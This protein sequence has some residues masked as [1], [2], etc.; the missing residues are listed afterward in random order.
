M[1]EERVVSRCSTLS[2][3]RRQSVPRISV[4]TPTRNRPCL[5]LRAIQSVLAQ[6]DVDFEVIVVDDGSTDD[7]WK[8]LGVAK[9]GNTDLI[10]IRQSGLGASVARNRGV[11]ESSG[12]FV[13]FLDSD[14]E[15]LPGA[16]NSLVGAVVNEDIVVVCSGAVIVDDSGAV[17]ETKHPRN[18]GPAYENQ[19]G[20]FLAG[21]FMVRRDVF[22]E[23]GGFDPACPST[24]HKDLALRLVPHC[25]RNG[26]SIVSVAATTVRVHA[27][28]GQHLRSDLQALLDGRLH[29]LNVHERQLRKS[30]R[31]YSYYCETAAV[32][33]A[34]LRRFAEAQSLFRRAIDS[35]PT[36]KSTY[37]RLVAAHIPA[38]RSIIWR[39]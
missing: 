16:L 10:L 18:L 26:H 14:D 20:L 27:H 34:K 32:Y 12:R 31:H 19:T 3:R 6:E 11:A 29:A 24:Q 23:I 8:T 15:L 1:R 9:E 21:T 35:C 25:V 39:P 30:A 28:A 4:I 22:D 13:L 5:T 17:V 2:H 36:K 38:L 33:A 37:L 7:T